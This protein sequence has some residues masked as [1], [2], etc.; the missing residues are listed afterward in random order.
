MK[1]NLL[2]VIIL[3][4]A[5]AAFG[6]IWT[7]TVPDGETKY[8]QTEITALIAERDTNSRWVTSSKRKAADG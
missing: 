1:K 2:S 5:T 6:E 8:L 3:V 7:I 4:A